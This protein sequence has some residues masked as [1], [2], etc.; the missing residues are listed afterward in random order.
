M[1]KLL[2]A[3]EWLVGCPRETGGGLLGVLRPV[4]DPVGA[5]GEVYR[6][7]EGPCNVRGGFGEACG[8]L[9]RAWRGPTM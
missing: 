8:G 3:L 2:G 5:C 6:A 4:K 1:D 9:Y 7:L